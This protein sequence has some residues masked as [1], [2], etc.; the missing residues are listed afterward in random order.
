MSK[1]IRKR[2]A[3][4]TRIKIITISLELFA[5]KDYDAVSVNEWSVT[6]HRLALLNL[7][8]MFYML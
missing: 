6:P 3:N 1:V 4:T 8:K 2:D 7:L 5:K